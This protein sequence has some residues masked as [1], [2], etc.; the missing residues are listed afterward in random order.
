MNIKEQYVKYNSTKF[1]KNKR[2]NTK[3]VF[4]KKERRKY[5]LTTCCAEYDTPAILRLYLATIQEYNEY[6]MCAGK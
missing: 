4:L 6:K 2:G 3:N 1:T 5:F